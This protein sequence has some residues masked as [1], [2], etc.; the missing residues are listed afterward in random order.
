[1]FNFGVTICP[2]T[3]MHSGMWAQALEMVA[4]SSGWTDISLSLLYDS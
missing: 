4:R 2:A 3:C 1:M